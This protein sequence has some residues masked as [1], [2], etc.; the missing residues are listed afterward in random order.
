MKRDLE[1][2]RKT[3][4]I[5]SNDSIGN[6]KRDTVI[7]C[8]NNHSGKPCEGI[9]DQ[10]ITEI[11]WAPL[12]SSLNYTGPG[13][14]GVFAGSGGVKVG[15]G[16]LSGMDGN[17]IN[18]NDLISYG[19]IVKKGVNFVGANGYTRKWDDCSSTVCSLSSLAL[20][21]L[22]QSKD[23]TDSLFRRCRLA[24]PLQSKSKSR[25]HLR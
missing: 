16:D 7:V 15:N 20:L 5:R 21:S 18:F 14:A 23:S 3:I 17:Q 4:D 8:P 1:R 25:S 19:V 6:S 13:G 24:F 9:T 22:S 10:N 12:G 11:N 2:N